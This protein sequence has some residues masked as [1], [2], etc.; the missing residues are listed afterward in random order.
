MPEG[1]IALPPA[2][3]ARPMPGGES[4]SFVEEKQLRIPIRGHHFAM[5][6][7]EFQ[8]ARDPPPAL[9]AADDFPISVVQSAASV[10]HHRPASGGPKDV[11]EGVNSILERHDEAH[12]MAHAHDQQ[13]TEQLFVSATYADGTGDDNSDRR[14][15]NAFVQLADTDPGD[16]CRDSCF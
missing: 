1:V 14:M 12:I 8:N 15:R 13:P 6:A 10:A 5:P 2:L 9:V 4:H 16:D 3:C 11:A 7:P